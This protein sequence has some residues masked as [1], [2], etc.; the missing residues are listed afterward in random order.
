[1]LQSI[2]FAAAANS[3]KNLLVAAP[4]GAGKTNVAMLTCLNTIHSAMSS[5]GVINLKEF[6]IVLQLVGSMV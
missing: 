5:T 3:N 4:T 6:K 1:M 2:V